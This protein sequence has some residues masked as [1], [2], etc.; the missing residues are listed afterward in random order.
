[1]SIKAT[2]NFF[3][4]FLHMHMELAVVREK[5]IVFSVGKMFIERKVTRGKGFSSVYEQEE[6][7]KM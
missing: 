1:M 4:L 5:K 3:F 7:K 2:K 6:E